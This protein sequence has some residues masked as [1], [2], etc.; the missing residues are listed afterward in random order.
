MDADRVE[1]LRRLFVTA[2]EVIED[3]HEAAMAGQAGNTGPRRYIKAAERIL[4]AAQQVRIL[5]EAA[6]IVAEDRA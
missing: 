2:A 6:A 3:M 4:L 1:L 5:A